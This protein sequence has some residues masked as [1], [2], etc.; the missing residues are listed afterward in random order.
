MARAHARGAFAGNRGMMGAMESK[1]CGEAMLDRLGVETSGHPF[2]V[3]AP[4][5]IGYQLHPPR[6]AHL[7]PVDG[8]AGTSARILPLAG[9]VPVDV[10]E[11][12]APEAPARVEL[13]AVELSDHLDRR[14]L[15]VPNLDADTMFKAARI[16]REQAERIAELEAKLEAMSPAP[17][18]VGSAKTDSGPGPFR[19]PPFGSTSAPFPSLGGSRDDYDPP[20]EDYDYPTGKLDCDG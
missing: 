17:G 10:P 3:R 14:G 7:T 11:H 1:S 12:R 18:Q 13:S 20:A 5:P 8:E 9:G 15:L 19:A 2:E 16:I 6:E 4:E